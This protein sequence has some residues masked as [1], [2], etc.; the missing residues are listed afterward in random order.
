MSVSLGSGVELQKAMVE[1]H[2]A[3]SGGVRLRS[4]NEVCV[5]TKD[6]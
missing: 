6:T 5:L 2:P 1:H 4:E 3:W